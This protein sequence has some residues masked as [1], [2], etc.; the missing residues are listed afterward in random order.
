MNNISIRYRLYGLVSL[1]I[2]LMSV[3]GVSTLVGL[4]AL[5]TEL[6]EITHEDI[7]LT[8]SLTLV[9]EYQLEQDLVFEKIYRIA[10]DLSYNPNANHPVMELEKEFD[11]L[12][13][14]VD[15]ELAHALK[16]S[17]EGI[18][19]AASEQSKEEFTHLKETLGHVKEEHDT[20]ADHVHQSFALLNSKQYDQFSQLASSI[21]TEGLE[22]AH[23]VEEILLEVE[24]FTGE[25]LKLALSHEKSV[26]RTM[27]ILT[28]FALIVGSLLSFVLATKIINTTKI[29]EDSVDIIGSGDLRNDIPIVT[30]DELGNIAHTINGMRGSFHDIMVNI[31]KL[32]DTLAKD[33]DAVMTASNET[34]LAADQIAQTV[35]D[36]A[37]GATEQ[38]EST[39]TVKEQVNQFVEM[40]ENME[41]S[42]IDSKDLALSTSQAVSSG[43]ETLEKQQVIMVKSQDASTK[44]GQEIHTL[45]EK[46]AK[47]SEIV[48]LITSISEQTNLL[49]LNAAIEAARAGEHGKGFAVVAEEVRKLAEQTVAATVGINDLI[50]EILVSVERSVKDVEL[51]TDLVNQQGDSVKVTFEAF[52]KIRSAVEDIRSHIE[53]T[54]DTSSDLRTMSDTVND[55]LIEIAEVTQTNAASTEEMA[56]ASEEQTSRLEEIS[57]AGVDIAK[58]AEELQ[59]LTLEFTVD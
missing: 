50:Q 57:A 4:N 21:E 54:A 44:V 26:V 10:T 47:I 37:A 5:T 41:R 48:E 25:A 51:T 35:S 39:A 42:L 52:D 18:D 59:T 58:R 28:I 17:Q 16:I 32:S 6:E 33:S 38:S 2:I 45:S 1:F 11:H 24:N 19:K 8:K 34:A 53:T 13:D 9:T 27:I 31:K 36:L 30:Q 46:S 40:T 3:I 23:K 14:L 20:F 29:I 15:A 43:L 12:N 56:A 49:A 55:H 7:P 22:L